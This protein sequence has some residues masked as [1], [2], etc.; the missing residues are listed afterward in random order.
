MFVF[1]TKV[2]LYAAEADSEFHVPCRELIERARRRAA[3]WFLTWGICY[4]FMRV[5][6]HPRVSVYSNP[7]TSQAAFIEKLLACP[8]LSVL[9]ATSIAAPGGAQACGQN[10]AN[11]SALEIPIEAK[12]QAGAALKITGIRRE[13]RL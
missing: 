3:P 1:D 12:R 4:E 13:G 8:G 10:L 11:S 9:T 2:F 6:T 7:W 5:A